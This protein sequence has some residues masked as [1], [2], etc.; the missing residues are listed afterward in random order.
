MI[1]IFFYKYQVKRG[2]SIIVIILQYTSAIQVVSAMGQIYF[3]KPVGKSY[4]I[5]TKNCKR[6]SLIINRTFSF[7]GA[8]ETY[9]YIKD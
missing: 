1:M 2:F 6:K 3:Y 9:H 5:K 7:K 4:N 8:N